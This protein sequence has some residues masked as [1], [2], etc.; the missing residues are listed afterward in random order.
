MEKSNDKNSFLLLRKH[1]EIFEKLTKEQAGELILAIFQYEEDNIEPDLRGVLEFAWIPIRQWLDEKKQAY[2]DRC[3]K[4]AE[5]GKKGGRGNKRTDNEESEKSER[6]KGDNE[7]SEKS[8]RKKKKAKKAE[9]DSDSDLDS[10]SDSDI[11][12]TGEPD[13]TPP[14][15][16]DKHK[17]LYDYYLTLGLVAHKKFTP[18]MK[19]AMDTAR[20]RCK[21]SFEDMKLWLYRHAEIVKLSAKSEYEVPKRGLVE[22]FGQSVYKG[23]ALICSEYADDGA[24]WLRYKDGNPNVRKNAKKHFENERPTGNYDHLAVD[25]FSDEKTAEGLKG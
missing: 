15:A 1:K 6:F 4:N 11:N 16:V 25:L 9:Y 3:K 23:T 18:E 20:R 8:E 19:N 17:A 24:K 10:D 22:F 12:N 7:E 13:G 2:S 21:C 5:N 14:P